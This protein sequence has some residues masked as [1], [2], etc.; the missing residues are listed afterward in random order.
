MAFIPSRM[1]AGASTVA[2][3][4]PSPTMSFVLIAASLTSALPCSR[5]DHEGE[6]REQ[7]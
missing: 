1:I 4:V 3:V 6:F 2:V 5:T 7:S